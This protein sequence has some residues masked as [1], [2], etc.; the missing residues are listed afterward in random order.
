MSHIK[1]PICILVQHYSNRWLHCIDTFSTATLIFV[2]TA[3][4]KRYG[5][6]DISGVKYSKCRHNL[7]LWF[8][9]RN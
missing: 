4:W 8:I 6:A 2:Q 7:S 3:V 5:G 1:A 9:P